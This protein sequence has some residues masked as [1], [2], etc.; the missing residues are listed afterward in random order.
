VAPQEEDGTIARV[1]FFR[2][3]PGMS[4]PLEE[5]LKKHMAWHKAQNGTWAWFVW[6]VE[7]GEATG[8]YGAGTFNHK[9]SDFDAPD[10]DLAADTADSAQNIL[11]YMAEGAQWRYY[12]RL[13][14]FSRP[15]PEGQGAAPLAVVLTFHLKMGANEEFLNAIAKVNHA[16]EKTKWPAH[17]EW[18]ALVN[19][20]E[21]PEF[22]LVLPHENYAAMAPPAVSFDK[23][24]EDAFGRAE[25]A[26]ILHTFDKT[27]ARET[28]E[29]VRDRPD[30]SYAPPKPAAPAA[31]APAAK[32]K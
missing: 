13:P 28:S 27:I 22:V 29:I 3:K 32:P 14:K 24:L 9:W 17:Y 10:V 23:M 19:G 20:G 7:T 25:A 18:Y 16:I 4:A 5:G 30:L 2:A 31:P 6:S 1:A 12:A 15:R 21:H 8:S 26:A 11:P